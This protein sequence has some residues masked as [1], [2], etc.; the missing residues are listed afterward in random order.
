MATH[1]AEK[2][3]AELGP[4][5]WDQWGTCPG[6]IVLGADL[7][8][9]SNDYADEGTAAHEL[10]ANCIDG[11][12]DAEDLLG[13]EYEVNGKIWPVTRDMAD[14]VDA[15]L[16]YIRDRVNP[17]RG[18]VLYS[19]QSVPL[20]W[21][22]GEQDAEGTSDVIAIVEAGK[23]LLIMDYKH[24]QGVKVYAS[25]Q[26]G[27][28]PNG[29]MAMYASGALEKYG[30]L[31]DEIE[32][33][34]TV[35][36]QPR[37]EHIDEFEMSVEELREFEAK[38]TLAAG[39]VELERQAHLEGSAELTLVPSDKG[40]KFCRAKHV[41]PA[42]RNLTSRT[43]SVASEAT[44][45]EDLTLPKQ[46]SS[47]THI[48]E[49]ITAEKLAEVM[50][51]SAMIETFIKAVRA[52]VERR[53]LAGEPVP[54]YYLGVG[55]AGARAWSDGELALKE[56]TK[57]GRLKMAEATT[58]KVIS[59]TQAEKLLKGRP[60]IWSQ[61]VPL[62]T[63]PA[64]GPSVCRDGDKNKPYLLPSSTPEDFDDLDAPKVDAASLLLDDG[65]EL[66]VDKM[67]RIANGA[68]A[69][70]GHGLLDD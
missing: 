59:P 17:E 47:A 14:A 66:L 31:Y 12:L 34:E 56:L 63:N 16:N 28:E 48:G 67:K 23:R 30:L 46:A 50:R 40:C 1:V 68:A 15:A 33:V 13:K 25:D 62:I 44:D 29:Q 35:I 57:S 10:L 53:L 41:C 22:T 38:V 2:A 19:E 51:A 45:F 52:E 39:A 27:L 64:G 20:Q 4:S 6:S 8:N 37:L 43:L 32:T 69:V 7:P 26:M 42:L 3:H 65:E 36:L 70:E 49:H 11:G 55:K 5:K 24:G 9:K 61:I 18:D 58:A 60:K 54:G 21:L